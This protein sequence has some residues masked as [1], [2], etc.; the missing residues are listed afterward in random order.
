MIKIIKRPPLHFML[1]A[2]RATQI[3]LRGNEEKF[4]F[5]PS[6]KN[7]D[8][9]LDNLPPFKY[10]TIVKYVQNSGKNIQPSLNCMVMKPFERG[11]NL[12]IEGYLH[13]V[14]A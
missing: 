6:Q 8:K 4:R 11:V 14:G 10:N 5:C 1:E 3:L 13:N 2:K 7:M 9:L 12:F